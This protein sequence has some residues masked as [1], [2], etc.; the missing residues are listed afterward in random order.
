MPINF[1]LVCFFQKILS[2]E[3]KWQQSSTWT[4]CW[5]TFKRSQIN[6]RKISPDAFDPFFLTIEVLLVHTYS[7]WP[8]EK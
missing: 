3:V 1:I 5:K 2:I 6:F 4:T 7:H 8:Y